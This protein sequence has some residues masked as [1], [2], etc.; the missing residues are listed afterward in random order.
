M[1]L[2]STYEISHCYRYSPYPSSPSMYAVGIYSIFMCTLSGIQ[3]SLFTILMYIK[4][5]SDEVEQK[6]QTLLPIISLLHTR[7]KIHTRFPVYLPE[8]IVFLHFTS[9]LLVYNNRDDVKTVE[10]I[11]LTIILYFFFFWFFCMKQVCM[12]KKLSI[13][14]Y[15]IQ[16]G[17]IKA[18]TIDIQ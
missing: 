6:K 12:T 1:S 15:K 2:L 18:F 11:V 14:S 5:F 9:L 16:K 8:L 4:D 17:F 3:R 10:T 13:S 7:K